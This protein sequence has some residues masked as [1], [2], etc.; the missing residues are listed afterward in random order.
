VFDNVARFRVA[1]R[2]AALDR[3]N[4]KTSRV[5][6]ANNRMKYAPT[7]RDAHNVTG[8]YRI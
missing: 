8:N 3:L 1:L 2:N 4:L 7:D 6:A 5:A